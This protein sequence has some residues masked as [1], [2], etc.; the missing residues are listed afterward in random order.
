MNKTAVLHVN[1]T[2]RPKQSA[3]FVNGRVVSVERTNKLLKAWKAG[4]VAAGRQWLREGNEAFGP[5]PLVVE[6]DFYFATK[7]RERWGQ[8]HMPRP[9]SDNLQKAMYDA[10][11]DAGV[12]RDDAQITDPKPRKRW[13]ETAG[14]VIVVREWEEGRDDEGRDDLDDIGVLKIDEGD[15]GE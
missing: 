2:P 5:V 15:A 4:I 6:V 7:K 14:A 1:G 12:I 3:R 9:D 11:K 10:L 13:A 8:P